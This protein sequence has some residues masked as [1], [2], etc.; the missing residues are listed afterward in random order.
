MSVMMWLPNKLQ[1][2]DV[3]KKIELPTPA[4]LFP[5]PLWTGK[6]I[7]SLIIP[8]IEYHAKSKTFDDNAEL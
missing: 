3:S 5:K 7:L 6:Q 1:Y 2:Q 4:I 8:D